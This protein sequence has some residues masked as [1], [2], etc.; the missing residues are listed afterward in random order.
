MVYLYLKLRT[1]LMATAGS[2]MQSAPS[3]P[4]LVILL[5]ISVF[6]LG[7]FLITR[8]L[9]GVIHAQVIHQDGE[10]LH[11]ATL[12]Q[13]FENEHAFSWKESSAEEQLDFIL[14][15]SKLR[16][17]VGLRLF[18]TNG[19]HL[20]SFPP[21]VLPVNLSAER[22]HQLANFQS[23]SDFRPGVALEQLFSAPHLGVNENLVLPFLHAYTPLRSGSNFVGAVEFIL[24]G[25]NVSAALA[26][27]DHDLMR[28][29]ILIFLVGSWISASTLFLAFRRL[30]QVNRLLREKTQSLIR[31]NHELTMAAKTSALGAVTA[32]L[33]HDLKNPLSGLH[34][35]V[36]DRIR[37]QGPSEDWTDAMETTRRMQAMVNEVVRILQ[38]ESSGGDYEMAMEEILELVRTRVQ[39]DQSSKQHE[40]CLQSRIQLSIPNRKANILVLVLSNLVQ[41]SLQ[42]LENPGRIVV[43]AKQEID[44]LIIQVSDTGPGLP[45]NVIENLFLPTPSRKKNGTGLG[46]AIS[47]QLANHLQ[48]KLELIANTRQGATFELRVDRAVIT[49]SNIGADP[50]PS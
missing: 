41:N 29:S 37:S 35:F 21:E 45:Q 42:A 48:A 13:Q 19:S 34:S 49:A 50:V 1:H 6:G 36:S 16:G 7:L 46:L 4:W 43:E 27:V 26:A 15:A 3:L 40:L 8:H 39:T 5:T 44:E 22:L 9:R 28:Y 25:A 17:V 23:I 10:V 14:Q 18:D 47:K 38:E 31:A 24:D 20:W 32:H 11:A 30:E 12:A 2:K 33:L